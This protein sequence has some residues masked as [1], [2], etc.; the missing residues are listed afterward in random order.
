M[1]QPSSPPPP[2]EAPAPP[3]PVA[4]A[5][6]SSALPST[7]FV[8]DPADAQVL[9]GLRARRELLTQQLEG[10]V[11]R[12]GELA[13]QL[14]NTSF[15]EGAIR[16]G[17]EQRLQVIDERVV[18]LERD[19]VATDRQIA[20]APPQLLAETE[21]AATVQQER[22]HHDEDDAVAAGFGGFGLGIVA[23]LVAGRVRR[24]WRRRRGGDAVPAAARDAGPDPR[25]DR[26]AHAVDAIAVEVERIGE[27]Q[28]FVTQLL[29]ESRA[30]VPELAAAGD[31][32]DT[33]AV[34]GARR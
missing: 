1:P 10:A 17:F 18:Q 34:P 8:G 31:G 20:G 3:A 9:A 2:P 28:R 22:D 26:L 16:K 21:H 6:G 11:D 25:I 32:P 23:L 15:A 14:T 30:R 24:W 12:R 33:Q 7:P 19:I 29:A 4:P 27:G 13:N 5:V